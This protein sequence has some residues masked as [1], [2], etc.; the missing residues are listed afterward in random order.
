VG[1]GRGRIRAPSLFSPFV[2]ESLDSTTQKL[3]AAN[4][5]GV[6]ARRATALA[7]P[8]ELLGKA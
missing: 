3:H 5:S 6:T 1:I 2:T 4:T 7:A 8:N